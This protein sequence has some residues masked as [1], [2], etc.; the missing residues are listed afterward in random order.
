MWDVISSNKGSFFLKAS[1]IISLSYHLGI[2]G[3]YSY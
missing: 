3:S 2:K 1:S